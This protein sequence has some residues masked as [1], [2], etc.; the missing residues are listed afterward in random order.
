MKAELRELIRRCIDSRVKLD[1]A[2][3]Y[4]ANPATA[5]TA[6]GVALRI[7]REVEEVRSGLAELT[8][9]GLLTEVALG[10]GRY[11]IYSLT[12]DAAL[13]QLLAD[14]SWSYHYS[15]EDRR[16]ITHLIV[17]R[18]RARRRAQDPEAPD[19]G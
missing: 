2:L 14:L 5:D 19:D 11:V 10:R 8:A 9:A 17:E 18:Q 4:Q 6:E 7:Y 15:A 3:F 16:E 12:K 13:R 1:V